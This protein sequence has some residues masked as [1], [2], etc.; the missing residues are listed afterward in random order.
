MTRR[1]RA[2]PP[3]AEPV[4]PSDLR[5]DQS[6]FMVTYVDEDMLVPVVQTL[7]FLGRNATGKHPGFLCFQDAESFFDLGPYPQKKRGPGDLYVC[8]DEGLSNIFTLEKALKSLSRCLE[9][10]TRKKPR[11]RKQ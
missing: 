4:T 1:G 7:I 5:K 9:R 2:V 8:P 3:Y 10:R 11:G 6:Y